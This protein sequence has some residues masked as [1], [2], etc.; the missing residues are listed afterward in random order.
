MKLTKILKTHYSAIVNRKLI[1]HQTT[2]DDFVDKLREEF[3]EFLDEIHLDPEMMNNAT[4]QECA[5]IMMVC[6]N[7]LTRKGYNVKKVLHENMMTQVERAAD[8]NILG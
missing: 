5:D 2:T 3:S 4:R 6:A 7:M 8:K 1:T